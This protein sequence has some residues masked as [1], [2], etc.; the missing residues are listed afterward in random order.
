MLDFQSIFSA[1]WGATIGGSLLLGAV[2]HHT[3]RPYEIDSKILPLAALYT[4]FIVALAIG[5][6][7]ICHF[8]LLTAL[9]RT[10]TV[11]AGFTAG[12]VGSMLAYR[13]FFHRLNHFP[14]PFA[15]RLSKFWQV[16]MVLRSDFHQH[17][18]VQKL[19]QEY[20]D[21]VR[22]GPREVSINRHSAIDLI[23]G[24]KQVCA[25]GPWYY[26]ATD[27]ETKVSL[28]NG[29][30]IDLHRKRKKAWERGLGFRA[31]AQYEPRVK[32]K[33]DL[34]LSRLGTGRPINIT[35]YAMF[36]GFDVMGDIGLSKEFNMLQTETAHQAIR[37]LHSLMSVFGLLG[38]V[39]W[40]IQLLGKLSGNG[41]PMKFIDWCNTE[42]R[43][44][45]KVLEHEKDSFKNEDPRD[46]STWLIKAMSENDP[47]GPPSQMALE[48]DSR[49]LVIAGSDTASITLTHCLYYFAKYPDCYRKLQ[50]LVDT[51]FP[52]GV[53]DWTYS[54]VKIPYLD[55][56]VNET[57]RLKPPSPSGPQRVTPPQ[58]LQVDDVFIPG[59]TVVYVP[60]YT[61]HRDT[62]YWESAIEFVPERWETMSAEKEPFL[63]F[64][65]GEFGCPGKSVAW[66]ELRM[67][68]SLIA[69]RF[70]IAFAPGEDGVKFEEEAKDYF[71]LA[72]PALSLVFTPRNSA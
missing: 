3:I 33:V 27:D 52:N 61:I 60:T 29:R 19:H 58:G 44:K 38:P 49:L 42:I 56:V 20:G 8:P 1:P 62:R 9:S 23:Y 18:E 31:L 4:S 41:G 21:F 55:H 26:S 70:D 25:K 2:S 57:L 12:V 50:E 30:R 13:A 34:L 46:V 69:L 35:E 66:M 28:M 24:P 48:E 10:V 71:T 7:T 54:K 5:Y 11:S 43:A 32:A 22:L 64:S 59:D 67:A 37:E 17:I 53:I 40:L 15:A 65:K 36:F 72:L 47:S 51:H 63:P 68:L 45:Q 39:P 14:G 16:R 6:V